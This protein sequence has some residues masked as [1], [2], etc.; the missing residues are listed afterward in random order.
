LTLDDHV[1]LINWTI[2]EPG[3]YLLSGCALSFKPLFRIFVKALRL[4]VFLTHTKTTFQSGKSKNHTTAVTYADIHLKSIPYTGGKFYLLSEDSD[5]GGEIGKM[6]V[7][8]TRTVDIETENG[9]FDGRRK[10]EFERSTPSA[11]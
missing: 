9:R 6:E 8:V 5:K 10:E 2:I 11:V 1:T 4:Q 3:I 7:L